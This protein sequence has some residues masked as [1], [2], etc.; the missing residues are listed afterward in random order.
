MSVHYVKDL[1]IYIDDKPVNSYMPVS[2]KDVL[3]DLLKSLDL[4][5]ITDDNMTLPSV[6]KAIAKA[7]EVL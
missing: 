1:K 2:Y 7:K 3:E 6:K 5:G 4:A